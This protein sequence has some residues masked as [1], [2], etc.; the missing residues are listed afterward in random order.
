MFLVDRPDI[1]YIYEEIAGAEVGEL[2]RRI[3][4][5]GAEICMVGPENAIFAYVIR[6][7][8]APGRGG[9]VGRVARVFPEEEKY[10]ECSC[11][12]TVCVSSK[13]RLVESSG[14]AGHKLHRVAMKFA[15]CSFQ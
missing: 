12:R 1:N 13:I 15:I 7:I 3:T 11:W 2:Q 10:A 8:G 4:S 9:P 5:G 6:Y 14:G